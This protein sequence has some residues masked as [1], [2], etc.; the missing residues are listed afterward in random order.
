MSERTLRWALAR[1]PDSTMVL[2]NLAQLLDAEGR[3]GEA[4]VLRERLARLQPVA[5]FHYFNLGRAAMASGDWQR[6]RRLFERELQRDPD[7]HEF[8]AWLAAALRQLG[9]H[10]RAD[11]HV[12]RAM[13]TST[14]RAD[15]ALY[16]A[17]LDRLRAQATQTPR[18]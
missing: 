9:D 11:A 12:K 15:H 8:H 14:T 3:K 6:A 4:G 5:P 16:A 2:N 13:D 10:R 18:H 1:E 17:K 7:Y